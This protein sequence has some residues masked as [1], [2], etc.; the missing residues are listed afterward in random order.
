MT[1]EF[2]NEQ[3]TR[4]SIVSCTERDQKGQS[5]SGE[6]VRI[7]Q[8]GVAQLPWSLVPRGSGLRC[9]LGRATVRSE[10]PGRPCTLTRPSRIVRISI[11]RASGLPGG[12]KRHASAAVPDPTYGARPPR[13]RSPPGRYSRSFWAWSLTACHPTNSPSGSMNV[14]SSVYVRSMAA[15]R[16]S[17]SRSEKTSCRLL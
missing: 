2:I 15:R 10:R 5:S 9:G 11:P 17:G 16:R 14:T 1:N 3:K 6:A 8:R 4:P 7:V 13:T 12:P